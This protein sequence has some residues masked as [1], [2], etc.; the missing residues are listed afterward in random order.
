MTSNII[1]FL[2][3]TYW[4]DNAKNANSS[5]I[6]SYEKPYLGFTKTTF[7]DQIWQELIHM[8]Q[9]HYPENDS[10]ATVLFPLVFIILSH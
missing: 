5:F 7:P 4:L 1:T 9:L 10:N 3:N 2:L 6:L 8:Q